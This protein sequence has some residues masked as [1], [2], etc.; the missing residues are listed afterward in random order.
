MLTKQE[1]LAIVNADGQSL[2]ELSLE[3]RN[4][5]DI[6]LAAVS[7]NGK[8][9]QYASSE[10][11]N[12]RGVVLAAVS[13]DGD[14]LQFASAELK[15]DREFILDAVS[16]NG[17]AL[18]C[19]PAELKNDRDIVLA[20]VSN[21]GDALQFA[22]AELK[23]DRDIVLAAVSQYG[24]ALQFAPTELKNDR[25]IVLAAVSQDSDALEH[26]PTE[27]Q[28]DRDIVLAA[29]SKNGWALGYASAELKNDRNIV[30][31]AVSNNSWALY[32]ASA[33]LQN[34]RDIVLAA[35][36]SEHYLQS[37]YSQRIKALNHISKQLRESYFYNYVALI[38][39]KSDIDEFNAYI[40][41]RLQIQTEPISPFLDIIKI[42]IEECDIE[43]LLWLLQH[44]AQ[45]ITYSE[46]E[47]K[48]MYQESS[49]ISSAWN[50]YHLAILTAIELNQPEIIQPLLEH[51]QWQ[52]CRAYDDPCL[53]KLFSALQNS[54]IFS[55][56]PIIYKKIFIQIQ[57][58]LLP[59]PIK[60]LQDNTLPLNLEIHLNNL[61]KALEHN[62]DSYFTEYTFTAL[63][64]ITQQLIFYKTQLNAF[65]KKIIIRLD[66]DLWRYSSILPKIENALTLID[67]FNY[68][69]TSIFE[70][71]SESI[72]QTHAKIMRVKDSLARFYPKISHL[73]SPDTQVGGVFC[74]F[75][76]TTSNQINLKRS[77]PDTP[78]SSEATPAAKKLTI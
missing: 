17:W 16:E 59:K 37:P 30:L 4:D 55:T 27:F 23:N 5:R 42:C 43:R 18:Q 1:A 71:E 73:L 31:A 63:N 61:S 51:T 41:S 65:E 45:N 11:K 76:N 33:E 3:K 72:T 28:N 8:S 53:I 14:A 9:L 44:Y 39:V 6:V 67:K 47:A 64:E 49:D 22:P 32:D 34:D 60:E 46:S 68:D 26:A 57:Q 70:N 20:A 38:A 10:L 12:D 7:Q 78:A 21:D 69:Y 62:Q 58:C 50:G 36:S 66:T 25:D 74:F 77:Q 54:D 15:K 52:T 56:S 29:V 40:L 2:Q 48:F 13:E 75:S 19:A 24:Y 35:V